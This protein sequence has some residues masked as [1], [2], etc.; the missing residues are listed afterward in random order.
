MLNVL[1]I[2]RLYPD[3]WVA[4]DRGLRILGHGPDLR[5]LWARFGEGSSRLTFYFASGFSQETPAT[6]R[7]FSGE[8][9]TRSPS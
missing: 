2:S 8:R 1:E 9:L 3:Q 6:R 5:E 7:E 4:L